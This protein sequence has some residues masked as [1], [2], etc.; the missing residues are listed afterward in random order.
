[1]IS[2]SYLVPWLT[3]L[4]CRI[5]ALQADA[6][7]PANVVVVND[8]MATTSF[9]LPE[10]VSDEPWLEFLKRW[11]LVLLKTDLN[12]TVK[13]HSREKL[14]F[15]WPIDFCIFS[16]VVRLTLS[17]VRSILYGPYMYG[18]FWIWS[19]FVDTWCIFCLIRSMTDNVVS[20]GV[21]GPIPPDDPRWLKWRFEHWK[22]SQ[23]E[24][25]NK[26]F[27]SRNLERESELDDSSTIF[28]G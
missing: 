17:F 5:S 22:F 11:N 23:I 16:F 13:I 9:I 7:W 24:I 3:I 4:F 27:K 26:N 14:T 1:M 2:R 6:H 18:R 19:R 15:T 21:H 12:S 10:L 25:W 8:P 28:F 20:A